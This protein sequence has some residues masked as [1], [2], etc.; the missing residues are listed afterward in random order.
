MASGDIKIMVDILQN[1]YYDV[2]VKVC[3]V[4]NKSIHSYILSLSG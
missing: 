2:Y 1:Q 4:L 3:F